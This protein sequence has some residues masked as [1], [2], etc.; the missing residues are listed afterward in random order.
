[1]AIKHFSLLVRSQA[2]KYGDREVF[3]HKDFENDKWISTSWTQFSEQVELI[4]LAFLTMG[5]REQEN[6]ATYTQ[7]RPEGLIIDF[8]AYENRAVVVPLYATSSQSQIEYI[9]NEAEVRFL[10]VGGQFQY[11][12]AYAARKNCTSLEK[13]IILD[14]SVKLAEDDTIS[15]RFEDLYKIGKQADN[16]LRNTLEQ[17]MLS[18]SDE[19]L[20]SIIY[21]S[22]TTGEPKGVML[23]NSNFNEAMR[24][25]IQRLK[26][27]S[28]KDI[29]LC[30]LPLTHIFE[31]A[32]TYF[33]LVKGIRVV[34][35]Q[36]PDEIQSVI[37]EVRPTIMCSVP[38]FW[39][40]VY[41]GVQEK[42]AETTGIK[43]ML[44]LDAI[45]VG[46]IHNL[47]Y[48]RVGKT[49]PRMIQLKY[50][51]Y[52][53]TIY[54][55]LKKTIGIENG[56]FFPTA[57]AAVPDEI[58][59]FVHSVGIDMLV[60]YGLTESTATV[61][62]TSKTG[63]DIGSVGQVMP[64]VE[65][66][67]GEDN[68]ILLR[69]KT[70]TKGYYKKAEAT[71]AAI[72]EEGWFHTGDAGYFKNGQLYLTERIKD[73]FKTSNGKYIAPQAL[74]TKLVIDRY[75]DQIAIIA[76][77]R[78]FVSALIVPV[79]GFVKQY[80]KEKGIEYK[81]MA[82]LLEHPKIT[83]LFRARIDTL[84]QQFA[85]YEQIKRFTLLPEPFSMEK[86]ELTNTLKLKRPVVARNYKEVIDK[87]YEE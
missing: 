77:Q 25:H 29:S 86:G 57:G 2:E 73:L 5:V 72:D 28:E 81:D 61:S 26:M 55:L 20:V 18:A 13:L 12:N 31:R 15:I 74:E 35:N 44:M 84:Q 22:G 39:E 48:L 7:N 71:A 58:C 38:R 1:M 75:I 11:D 37:K 43:K 42:I 80:A 46:R 62:C 64:E 23:T 63:Y 53:K 6:I 10:F 41:A 17:R 56:N 45:K 34:I 83:A 65:V 82:E 3:R 27:V 36:K 54:A 70:I 21:T 51:F 30:F 47:D 50:K 19:D 60:G 33:C 52:E 85:H 9:I 79:Y 78:K 69:G 4:A 68:E 59:E 24:I 76:D 32:W 8:A 66:K 67:I 87:M 49:P 16:A 40:K 14:P